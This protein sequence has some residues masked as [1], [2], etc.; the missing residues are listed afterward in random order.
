VP[1]YD[2]TA[3]FDRMLRRLTPQQRRQYYKALDQFVTWPREHGFDPTQAPRTL[4]LH[5]LEGKSPRPPYPPAGATFSKIAAIPCP[6]PM[7][8]V[9]RP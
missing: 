5:K 6:P 7:H 3:A 9:S 8:I 1:T 2:S 4:R